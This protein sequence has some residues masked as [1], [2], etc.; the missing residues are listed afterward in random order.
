MG[1]MGPDLP[2]LFFWFFASLLF[3]VYA[4]YPLSVMAV[5]LV[6]GKKVK[7][8]GFQPYISIVIAA[9]NEAKVIAATIE[10]KLGLDYPAD[11]LEI[12]VVS[13]SSDDGTDEIVSRYRDRHVRLIR[14]TP[15]QGKTSG[16]NLAL[17]RAQGEIIVFSDS[18]SI[19][20]RNA[21]IDI[22]ADFADPSVGYV[23][24]KMIY[25]NPDGSITGDGCSAYMKYENMLRK[26]ESAAGSAVGVDGGIDAIRKKLFTPMRPDQLPDFI[27]P[28][29]VVEQGYRVVYEPAALLN[30]NSLSSPADEYRMRVRVSLRALNA[31]KDMRHLM[32]PFKYGLFAWQLFSHK[33]LRYGAFVFL[34]SLYVCNLLAIH[35]GVFYRLFFLLQ[36]AFY[37]TAIVLSCMAG[38]VKPPRIFY[39]PFYFCLVNAASMH[40]FWKF[41]N[42]EKMTT[43]APRKG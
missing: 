36:N 23:T 24:G 21:L 27:L 6:A 4:L 39:V 25:V 2:V 38:R 5:S 22:A 26:F 8:A 12:I 19:Y 43:W 28:L 37:L 17:P 20:S 31:L 15:R 9:Y 41:M 40:A 32:N 33:L 13:D 29:K 34:L 16:L 10:N 1:K 30:E 14:Q 35:A 3:Y 18:N 11:R 42:H 7:K